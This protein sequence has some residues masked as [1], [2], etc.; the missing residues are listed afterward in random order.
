[1]AIRSPNLSPVLYCDAGNAWICCVTLPLGA[2]TYCEYACGALGRKPGISRH[3]RRLA[4]TTG[5]K[6]GLLDSG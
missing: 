5:E 1:M 3:L 2:S 4:T 6:F